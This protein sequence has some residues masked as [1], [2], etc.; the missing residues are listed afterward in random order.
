MNE[1]NDLEQGFQEGDNN[2]K[3]NLEISFSK[4]ITTISSPKNVN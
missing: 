4:S 2:N 1:R 3:L